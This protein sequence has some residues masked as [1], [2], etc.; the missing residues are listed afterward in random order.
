MMDPLAA[1]EC[2]LNGIRNNDLY[3]LSHPEYASAAR[4]RHEA[5]MESFQKEPV[6]PAARVAI[7]Q[8]ARSSIYAD[9]LARKRTATSSPENY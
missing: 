2:V 1:G 7:A 4:E 6:S 9:V 5:I 3:I 8:F